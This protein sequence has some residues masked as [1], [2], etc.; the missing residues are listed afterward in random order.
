MKQVMNVI[1]I[2]SLFVFGFVAF[3]SDV[4][5]DSK[6]VQYVTVSHGDTLWSIADS[7]EHR[8]EVDIRDVIHTIKTMNELQES[9]RLLPGTT[10][11]VPT[12]QAKKGFFQEAYVASN[13]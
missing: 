8:N 2:C 4:E 13:Q 1:V 7:L 6:R 10:I 12:I 11:K 5:I 3:N 9:E